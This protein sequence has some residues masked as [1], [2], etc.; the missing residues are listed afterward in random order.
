M[1]F[2]ENLEIRQQVR[3]AFFLFTNRLPIK[4][5]NQAN[6]SKNYTRTPFIILSL[7]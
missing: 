1:F 7:P 4:Y 6:E 3:K 5:S 2:F